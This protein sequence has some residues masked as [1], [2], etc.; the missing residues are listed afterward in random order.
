MVVE[1][2]ETLQIRRKI[3]AQKTILDLQYSEQK[4]SECCDPLLTL[5]TVY[6]ALLILSSGST[7]MSDNIKA[8][9]PNFSQ[10]SFRI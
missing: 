1:M 3:D 8:N 2:V 9:R 6:G 7:A 5:V 4:N 10:K